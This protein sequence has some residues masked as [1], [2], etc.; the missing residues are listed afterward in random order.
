MKS[1]R[2]AVPCFILLAAG[3]A[4]VPILG[5]LLD[6]DTLPGRTSRAEI[7][8]VGKLLSV[9]ERAV[10]EEEIRRDGPYYKKYYTYYDLGEVAVLEIL[11][12]SYGKKEL[13]IKFLSFDQTQPP[14]EKI[15]CKHFSVY[16]IWKPGIWLID[17]DTGTEPL[18]L[19]RRGNY[20]PS[21][22]RDDV[23]IC[24]EENEGK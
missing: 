21:N 2:Y 4:K 12:G 20:L 10:I 24:I 3:C 9:N 23:K 15:D 1:S 22:R 5:K 16:D 8:I 18:Y 11:K 17:I 19:V 7:I 6:N 14:Q 13:F